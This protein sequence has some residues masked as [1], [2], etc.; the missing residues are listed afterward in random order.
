MKIERAATDTDRRFLEKCFRANIADQSRGCIPSLDVEE[1]QRNQ[2]GLHVY[3]LLLIR[4]EGRHIAGGIH[5]HSPTTFARLAH[6]AAA[7]EIVRDWRLL[8]HLAV[9][10]SFRATGIGKALVVRL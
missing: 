10:E 5:S 3:A 4:G 9:D 2:F 7:A 8:E 6:D 1:R